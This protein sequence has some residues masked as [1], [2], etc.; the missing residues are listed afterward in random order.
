MTNKANYD[1]VKISNRHYIQVE[2]NPK[3]KRRRITRIFART[4]KF[5]KKSP[6]YVIENNISYE[7]LKNIYKDYLLD[8]R[9]NKIMETARKKYSNHACN[10]C[11]YCTDSLNYVLKKFY[12][13]ETP[14][15]KETQAKMVEYIKNNSTKSLKEVIKKFYKNDR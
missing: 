2:P 15:N 10:Y 3:D 8:K 14:L 11:E 4:I 9:F 13:E 5:S 1:D 7:E 6:E 12:E